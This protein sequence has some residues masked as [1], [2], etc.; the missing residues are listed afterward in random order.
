M[1]SDLVNEKENDSMAADF[2][3]RVRANHKHL[4]G[5]L[6]P[7]YDFVICGSGSS[8][9]VVARRLAENPD[10]SV[11]L[12][13]AGG[14]DD[15]PSVTDAA[16]WPTNIGTDRDW[17]FVGLPNPNLNGRSITFSMGK[18]LGGGSAINVML[19]ARGHQS[20]W[21]FFA[22]EAD[23]P[24][25]SY[26][27]VLE[28]YSRVEDWHGSPDPTYRGS[29]GPVYVAPPQDPNP[30]ALATVHGAKSIGIPAFDSPNGKMM[31]A[32]GGAALADIRSRN[33]NRHSV[34]RSYVYPYLDR[35]NLTVVTR[36]HVTRV[37]FDGSRAT[38]VE[39]SHRGATRVVAAEYEVVLSMG[40]MHSPKVLMHSGIGDQVQLRSLG[41]P[42]RQHLAG[43]GQNFQDHVAFYCGWEYQVPLP[44][45]NNMSEATVYWTTAPT[46]HSPDVFICQAEIPYGTA[47][48]VA[49]F[50]L[51]T[52][53]WSLVGGL[54][55]PK[56][57]GRLRLT[58]PNPCDPIHVDA[59]TLAEPD[60]RK[61]AIACVQLCREIGNSAPLRPFARREVMPG[62]VNG[63]ELEMFVRDAA[64]SY[65]HACGTAKMGRDPMS[66]VDGALKVHGVENLRI[67][68]ASVMPRVTTGNTMA[69]CVIIGERAAAILKSEHGL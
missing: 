67:A 44:P 35:P 15:V 39:V 25:W 21:D 46:S 55:Q 64:T 54:A 58:G 63:R 68:D 32:P 20:D 31:E 53:G 34:F 37:T 60:D 2:R 11:L 18:V 24:A 10:V 61:A 43:V 29:G 56:S 42:V 66:V 30:L 47:E 52:A 3:E 69:P 51:P 17:A 48:T 23:D 12:L 16:R 6:Q 33:G 49:Q 38:G 28:T 8:G 41:I 59:N 22:S 5:E 26:A 40:A 57:R 7:R 50:G 1:S 65:W 19:W 4:A 27:S 14:G 45:R 36:A 9:S 62:N 13:E